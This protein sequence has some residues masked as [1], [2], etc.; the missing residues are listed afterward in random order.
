MKL[1]KHQQGDLVVT[2]DGAPLGLL[3]WWRLSGDTSLRALM[4]AAEKLG[5]DVES[6]PEPPSEVVAL[7]RAVNDSLG[8]KQDKNQ[9][10]DGAW[11][12]SNIVEVDVRT[13]EG[14]RKKHVRHDHIL[15]VYFNENQTLTCDPTHP[16]DGSVHPDAET[17]LAKICAAYQ[18]N[19]RVLSVQDIAMF[20]VRQLHVSKAASLRDRGGVY[21]VPADLQERWEA[22]VAVIEMA[23]PAHRV[24]DIPV[25]STAKLVAEVIDC[26]TADAE[27]FATKTSELILND[28]LGERALETKEVQFEALQEKMRSYEALLGTRMEKMRTTLDA[29]EHAI[30]LALMKAQG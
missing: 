13:A 6:L 21:L 19:L 24:M 28:K 14:P 9:D 25:R 10:K 4:Q 15:K 12:V 7:S 20:L 17:M 11:H 16:L 1:S 27:D 30:S 18:H 26:L 2:E 22:A 23:S 5:F 3:V 29:I 8:A